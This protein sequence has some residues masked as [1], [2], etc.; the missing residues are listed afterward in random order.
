MRES[1]GDFEIVPFACGGEVVVHEITGHRVITVGV[2]QLQ[3]DVLFD[4]RAR[5][6]ERGGLAG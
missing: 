4:G 1:G 2:G 5:E 3:E 6:F